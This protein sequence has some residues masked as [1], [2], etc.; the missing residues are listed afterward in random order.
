MSDV[1][2]IKIVTDIFD[3]EKILLIESMPDADSVIVIWF[4]LLCLAGKQNN[5]GV[6]TINGR[7]P[8]TDEM[9]ATIMRR[10]L[11][12]V[13]FALRAFEQYGM[14]EIINDTITI[15]KWEKHQSLDALERARDA[16]RQRVARS[17]EKQKL[18]ASGECNAL[19]S[20][21][22]NVTSGVTVTL[23]NGGREDK[24][25]LD[26][27]RKEESDNPVGSADAPPKASKKFVKPGIEEVRDYC[28]SRGNGID[29]EYWMDYYESNGWMV[30]KDHM[31]DWKAT[32]RRW[33]HNDKVRKAKQAPAPLTREEP[34]RARPHE[35]L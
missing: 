9:F 1:K 8:Y 20:A 15:P 33:E 21:T 7:M 11:N 32:V 3:D 4:K 29:A 17:R 10:P 18:L 5:G 25:R 24:S 22:C 26:K 34:E 35:Y 2:W 12:T 27:T 23:G 28:E 31:K 14:I 30:G 6:F 19:R 16:T 13:R